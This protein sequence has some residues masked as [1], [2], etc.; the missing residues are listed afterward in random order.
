[1]IGFT[2][3]YQLIISIH[4]IG[5]TQYIL[6]GNNPASIDSNY[7]I[8]TKKSKYNSISQNNLILTSK[9]LK[10]S[11]SN[12]LNY[13]LNEDYL[14]KSLEE[15]IKK[16][17]ICYI[18]ALNI[19]YIPMYLEY[20]KERLINLK[21]ISFNFN[22]FHKIDLESL[23]DL[24]SSFKISN[25]TINKNT[26]NKM[27]LKFTAYDTFILWIHKEK[28]VLFK[29]NKLKVAIMKEKQLNTINSEVLILRILSF[30]EMK[31]YKILPDNS[32]IYETLISQYKK[33]KIELFN[34]M[35]CI[36]VLNKNF[37]VINFKINK[38]YKSYFIVHI[39]V[40]QNR[41]KLILKMQ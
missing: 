20:L 8:I 22:D 36:V 14:P 9:I 4:S 13:R 17:E 39:K 30:L 16:L 18:P 31:D 21:C 32:K 7:L 28:S 5:T 23:I 10:I 41:I 19:K 38:T 6:F 3:S 25:L 15:S 35:P 27:N 37:Q 40:I 33:Y 11:Y 26:K 1:M 24:H 12:L 2:C 29:V 34:H